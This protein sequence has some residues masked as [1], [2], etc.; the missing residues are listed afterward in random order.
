MRQLLRVGATLVAL[1]AGSLA[2]IAVAPAAHA[3]VTPLTLEQ[4]SRRRVQAT[5]SSA[6]D[7]TAFKRRRRGSAG[8]ALPELKDDEAFSVNSVSFGVESVWL[9]A[10][11]PP[12]RVKVRIYR[13]PKGAKLTWAGLQAAPRPSEGP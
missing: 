4:A 11:Q 1:I 12:L 7:R 6:S 10:G 9:P 13:Y 2:L 5:R 8:S 3:A